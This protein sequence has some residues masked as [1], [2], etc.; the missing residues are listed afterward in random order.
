[1]ADVYHGYPSDS[2]R[3]VGDLSNIKVNAYGGAYIGL[4]DDVISLGF[5]KTRT[6]INLPLMILGHLFF[7]D[8]FIKFV[9]MLVLA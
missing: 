5:N 9:E 3:H 1:M 6:V 8:T 7:I 2:V 4:V